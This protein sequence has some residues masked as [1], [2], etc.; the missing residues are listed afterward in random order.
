M[1]YLFITSKVPNV[2]GFIS[3]YF[4]SFYCNDQFLTQLPLREIGSLMHIFGL[5]SVGITPESIFLLLILMAKIRKGDRLF[6][7][8][9]EHFN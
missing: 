6:I 7:F 2:T 9:W 8:P 4:S 1:N 3:C 5:L